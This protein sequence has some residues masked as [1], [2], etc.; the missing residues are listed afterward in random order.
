MSRL[1]GVIWPLS[2]ETAWSL[3][4]GLRDCEADPWAHFSPSWTASLLPYTA[5]LPW[6]QRLA[7]ARCS[8]PS[9]PHRR[10]STVS[11]EDS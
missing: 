5:L 3:A 1:R 11:H 4:T 6:R 9:T 7:L 2:M 8:A 10:Q